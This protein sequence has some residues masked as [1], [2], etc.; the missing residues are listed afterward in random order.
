MPA[1]QR[2]APRRYGRSPP[3]TVG[4]RPA[5]L[6]IEMDDGE[7]GPGDRGDRSRCGRFPVG[8]SA[9]RQAF[10]RL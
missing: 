10:G 9:R 6:P 8:G 4:T 7:S 1:D 5:R 3:A 2:L